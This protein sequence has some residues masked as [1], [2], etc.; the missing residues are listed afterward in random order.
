[1][2]RAHRF[3]CLT[4]LALAVPDAVASYLFAPGSEK[5]DGFAD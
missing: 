4:I 1:M 5:S 3:P 2:K